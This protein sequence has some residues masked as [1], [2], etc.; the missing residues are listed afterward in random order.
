MHLSRR[1]F[2]YL[3]LGLLIVICSKI[4]T[5]SVISSSE[6][7]MCQRTTSTFDPILSTGNACHKKM[8]VAL[9]VRNGQVYYY[10]L[11]YNSS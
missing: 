1:F 2:H 3:I 8:L 4:A 5:S 9:A 11:Q 10:H 6:V 7:Q